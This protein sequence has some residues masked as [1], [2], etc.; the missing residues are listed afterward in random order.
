MQKFSLSRILRE[1]LIRALVF[2]VGFVLVVSTG[3]VSVAYAANGGLFGDILNKILASGNWEAPGDG[4][5][6]NA[7]KLGN[8]PASDFVKVKAW[9]SCGVGK[10]VTGFQPDGTVDCTP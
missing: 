10:C 4:T 2:G 8:I 7:E 3:F 9:Q 5:V 6:A 1:E